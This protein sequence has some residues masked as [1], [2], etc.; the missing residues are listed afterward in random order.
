MGSATTTYVVGRSA[1][2]AA[3][4]TWQ[5]VTVPIPPYFRSRHLTARIIGANNTAA[6]GNFYADIETL[7]KVLMKKKVTFL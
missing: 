5:T 1:L 3:I 4:G 7:E 2:T 6:V